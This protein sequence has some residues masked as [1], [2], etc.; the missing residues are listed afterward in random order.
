MGGVMIFAALKEAADRGELILVPDGLCR[1]HLRRDGVVV[2][3]DILVLPCRE[4][5]GVGK[6]MVAL[7]RAKNPG[8]DVVARC[9]AAYAANAFWRALGFVPIDEAGR[10]I[11]WRLCSS[12]VATVMPPTPEPPSR[13]AGVTA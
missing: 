4:G 6:G 2:I 3:R 12:S 5:T 1:W 11:E 13:A 8:A 9:P 10:V 7:V